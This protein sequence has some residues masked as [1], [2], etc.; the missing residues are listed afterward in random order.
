MYGCGGG[1]GGLHVVDATSGEGRKGINF[2]EISSILRRS[3]NLKSRRFDLPR[4]SKWSSLSFHSTM[5]NHATVEK[6]HRETSKFVHRRIQ[7]AIES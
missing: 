1:D 3:S 6:L 5:S 2:S 7:G 4:R